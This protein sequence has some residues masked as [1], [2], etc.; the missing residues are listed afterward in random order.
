MSLS[1][2]SIKWSFP[3][4]ERKE[5][6]TVPFPQTWSCKTWLSLYSPSSWRLTSVS[7]A[8]TPS[9]EVPVQIL[10]PTCLLP[11]PHKWN[12]S[13]NG[14]SS[15]PALQKQYRGNQSI[16]LRL[17]RESLIFSALGLWTERWR[18]RL[19]ILLHWTTLY[20]KTQ[21][22]IILFFEKFVWAVLELTVHQAGIQL[23]KLPVSASQELG[24]EACAVT[25]WPNFANRAETSPVFPN[26][27]VLNHWV[28]N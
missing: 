15:F 22:R 21:T 17:Q 7:L 1:P 11:L 18:C 20:L 27:R 2:R 16:W 8:H 19:C 26:C 24:F 13:G 23:T 10:T 25:A 3:R 12:C 5:W 4:G 9:P 14:G 28:Q 6:R